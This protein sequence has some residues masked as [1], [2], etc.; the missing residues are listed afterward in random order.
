MSRARA[1]ARARTCA[2]TWAR[3]P[4]RGAHAEGPGVPFS[5]DARPFRSTEAV[6]GFEPT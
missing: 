5:W 1:R 6:I 3:G 2:R 4:Y